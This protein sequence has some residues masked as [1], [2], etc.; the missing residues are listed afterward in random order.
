VKDWKQLYSTRFQQNKNK[1]VKKK[2]NATARKHLQ[3]GLERLSSYEE[4]HLLRD[5]ISSC[6][7]FLNTLYIN[8]NLAE[9]YLHLGYA[10]SLR[11]CFETANTFWGLAELLASNIGNQ[12]VL[13]QVDELR[14]DVSETRKLNVPGLI[15]SGEFTKPVEDKLDDLF[16]QFDE[17][18][19]GRWTRKDFLDFVSATSAVK[20]KEERSKEQK[21]A[22]EGDNKEEEAEREEEEASP[23][24]DEDFLNWLFGGPSGGGEFETDGKGRLTLFGFLSFYLAQTLEDSQETLS[25]LAAHGLQI[26]TTS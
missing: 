6:E 15:L 18:E 19:D 20:R 12:E 11:R 22:G 16:D 3:T 14:K 2:Q 13:S 8:P 21:E 24:P 7:S 4:S 1:N 10:C 26:T 9:V 23:P 17:D 5:L 25:D